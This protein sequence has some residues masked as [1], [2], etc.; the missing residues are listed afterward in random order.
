MRNIH[1]R[2]LSELY[3]ESAN[4]IPCLIVRRVLHSG[5]RFR[6]SFCPHVSPPKVLKIFLLNL[7]PR[8]TFKIKQIWCWFI[9][10]QHNPLFYWSSNRTQLSQINPR[11][12]IQISLNGYNFHFKTFFIVSE[13][14]KKI[15][16]KSYDY[17]VWRAEISIIRIDLHWK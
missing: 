9:S 7:I 11:R 3:A 4:P 2:D 13:Y 6:L 12:K 14:L 15:W 16:Q 8:S 1:L 5:G 17:A 10:V